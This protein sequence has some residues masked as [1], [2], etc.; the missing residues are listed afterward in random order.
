MYVCASHV[1]GARR[2]QKRA[3][4]LLELQLQMVVNCHVGTGTSARAA[5][6]LNL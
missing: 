4:D 3:S 6:T 5:S 1:C 2:G